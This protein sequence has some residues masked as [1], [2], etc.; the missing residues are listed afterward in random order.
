MT[1]QTPPITPPPPDV[2]PSAFFVLLRWLVVVLL[3]LLSVMMLSTA[4]R[5]CGGQ[6]LLSPL[7]YLGFFLVGC[8]S[9]AALVPTRSPLLRSAGCFGSMFVVALVLSIPDLVR[10]QI[11]SNESISI[12]D[13]RGMLSAQT[14]Y[15]KANEGYFDSRLSCLR[16]PAECIPGAPT[17]QGPFLGAEFLPARCGYV[18]QLHPG[19]PPPALPSTASPSSLTA[20]AYT[21]APET[22]GQSG[23]RGFCADSAGNL[24]FTIDGT[25]PPVLPD[26]TC[27][28]GR[29]FKIQ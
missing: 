29:C 13:L 3:A 19:L 25:A 20:F 7:G 27:D 2:R 15:S 5:P 23:V 8:A 9:V 14:A 1:A 16:R 22:P 24:C 6:G 17:D 18:R 21:A 26:G 10:S 4:T 12:A 11:S 28:L